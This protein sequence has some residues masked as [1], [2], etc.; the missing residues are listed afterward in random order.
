MI[1]L[2]VCACMCAGSSS[3][4][5]ATC[6]CPASA[7]AQM[8][9]SGGCAGNKDNQASK[10]SESNAKVPEADRTLIKLSEIKEL[11]DDDSDNDP[12]YVPPSHSST[13]DSTISSDSS[14]NMRDDD[15]SPARRVQKPA[16]AKPKAKT[17]ERKR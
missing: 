15:P 13:E 3:L 1:W 9:T 17:T 8:A 14:D 6:L 12:D 11:S 4:F 16:K 10:S 7:V 5:E 2:V